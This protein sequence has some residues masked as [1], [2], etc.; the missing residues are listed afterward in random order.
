MSE[1]FSGINQTLNDIVITMVMFYYTFFFWCLAEFWRVAKEDSPGQCLPYLPPLGRIWLGHA[2]TYYVP[3]GVTTV[4]RQHLSSLPSKY[5]PSL[6]LFDFSDRMRTWPFQI[7]TT[8]LK[9]RGP[10]Y[11]VPFFVQKY[12]NG[13]QSVIQGQDIGNGCGIYLCT[14]ISEPFQFF[15]QTKSATL[16][17]MKV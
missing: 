5:E 11:T 3:S 13:T 10:I 14:Y 8:I 4:L 6:T 12:M 7:D 15:L 16:I 1:L 2:R 17:P 9:L